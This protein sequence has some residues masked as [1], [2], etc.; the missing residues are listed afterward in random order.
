[1]EHK[2][3]NK[4]QNK[5]QNKKSE[6]AITV[7]LSL[8]LLLILSLVMT[9]IEGAR[10]NTARI[11]AERSL[12]TAMDSVLAEF[13][14]PLFTEYHL[15][16]LE[17]GYGSEAVNTEEMEGKLKDYMSYTFTPNRDLSYHRSELELYDISVDSLTVDETAGLMDYQGKLFINEAVEYMKYKELGNGME[18]LLDKMSL[19][20][21]PEKVSVLYEEK[22][23][24]EKELVAIDEGILRLMML[25]DGIYMTEKGLKTDKG[26]A[27]L[28][29]PDYIK[30]LCHG[31][32]TREKTGIYN[33]SIFA[34]VAPNYSDPDI[35]FSGI[36]SCYQ[37][38][39]EVLAHIASLEA[40]ISAIT[41][42][43][44]AAADTLGELESGLEAV[45]KD[46]EAAKEA[47]EQV[48]ACKEYINGLESQLSGL[49]VERTTYESEKLTL[50]EELRFRVSDISLLLQ[51]IEVLI[52]QAQA[53]I[54][55]ILETSVKADGLISTYEG[56][57]KK[58]RGDLGEEIYTTM[59]EGLQDLKR[60][61]S[62]N[63]FG[64]NFP[65]MKQILEENLHTLKT[66]E[67][68]LMQAGT[69]LD[70]LQLDA[71][72]ESITGA[73]TTLKA[74]RIDGLTLDYSTLVIEK[75]G[76]MDPLGLITELVEQGLTGL[77]LDPSEISDGR[78]TEETLPSDIASLTGEMTSGFDFG[79][80]FKELVIGGKETGMES[81][82]GDFGEYD[83]ASK[84][85]EAANAAAEQLLLQAYLQEHF[86]R[87][88]M[89]GEDTSGRKPSALSYEQE[90]LLMGHRTDQENVSSVIG[91]LILI[92]TIL[93]FTSILGDHAKRSEARTYAIGLVGFTGLT[94]LVSI[95]QTVLMVLL[96]FGEALVDTCALLIGKEVPIYKKKVNLSYSE[97]LS[98]TREYI[99]TKAS[100]YPEGKGAL[101]LSYG[102]Y[103]KI[104]LFFK[105]KQEL[106]YRSM[107]LIQE[108][109]KIRYE[110][111]LSMKKMLFGFKAEAVFNIQPKFLA[112]AFVRKYLNNP[113]QDFRFKTNAEY[114]Y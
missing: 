95:T 56:S 9:I 114:S 99:H 5:K 69:S 104:F 93:D 71:A 74:Y 105:S 64:Y 43:L 52:P 38:L 33:E 65:G 39:E 92:R 108:N 84:L 51:A 61:Q 67:E 83:F 88:P 100:G 97:L 25:Y 53:V 16:A 91:R 77:V 90:Y 50:I 44:S 48:K 14:A 47:R 86:Y 32:A 60:Y 58:A 1:M 15:L 59:E 106:S 13:Y 26:G 35:M 22:L 23:T 79:T 110:T 29:V 31:G 102:D 55:E 107:D 76:S 28:T 57:L 82:F 27:L 85:G 89:E 101:A 62:G 75:D 21:E 20:E 68:K 54:D 10:I 72:M 63:P 4:K 73:E 37:R 80:L 17:A 98:L 2:T 40:G 42:S 109:L 103:L 113:E 6:G 111:S 8:V 70:N 87:L 12:T 11:I 7:F 45:K 24:V 96:A 30:R 78:L 66:T 112:L 19:L 81:L 18:L 34:A 41:Q 46:K 3:L 49:E 94:I 36:R